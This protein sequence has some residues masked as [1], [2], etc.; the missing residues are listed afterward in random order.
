MRRRGTEV[1][2]AYVEADVL[3][4]ADAQSRAKGMTWSEWI[5]QAVREQA[6]REREEPFQLLP[7]EA[8]K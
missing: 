5:S 6:K 1:L 8:A 2:Q 3:A 4:L 7:Q